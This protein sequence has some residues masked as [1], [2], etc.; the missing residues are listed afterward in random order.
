M[1]HHVSH[2]A[3]PVGALPVV[4]PLSLRPSRRRELP[5]GRMSG[6]RTACSRSPGVRSG[7]EFTATGSA[8]ETK[9]ARRGGGRRVKTALTPVRASGDRAKPGVEQRSLD[10]RRRRSRGDG[11]GRTGAAERLSVLERRARRR[12]GAA[13]GAV[14]VLRGVRGDAGV[15]ARGPV[16]TRRPACSSASSITCGVCRPVSCASSSFSGRFQE[17][18]RHRGSLGRV[19]RA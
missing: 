5:P 16:P 6:R 10:E 18:Q 9:K 14:G 8:A 17:P 19:R 15:F 4:A 3:A 12:A 7:V 2:V 13:C 11:A 1:R